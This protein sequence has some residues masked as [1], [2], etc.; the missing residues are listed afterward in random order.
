MVDLV[1]FSG[2]QPGIIM[3]PKGNLAISGDILAIGIWWEEVR[4]AAKHSIMCRT[5]QPPLPMP[6]L[7][8]RIIL[9][10]M[11]IMARLR[12]PALA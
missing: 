12:N 8:Q 10:Q 6:A 9:P 7:R 3:L 11:S 2:S 4:D 1:Q 5:V